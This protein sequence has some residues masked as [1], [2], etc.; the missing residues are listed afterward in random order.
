MLVSTFAVVS[1]EYQRCHKVKIMYDIKIQYVKNRKCE[2][3]NIYIY[4]QKSVS[5]H[6]SCK[7]LL[8]L[9][10]RDPWLWYP[11]FIPC[12]ISVYCT[13]PQYCDTVHRYYAV[14]Y[15][16]MICCTLRTSVK[17]DSVIMSKM[18]SRNM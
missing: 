16:S 6:L 13:V 9:S 11:M 2:R 14:N 5:K 17:S 18:V 3:H 12:V 1:I 15:H 7:S 8:V 10:G 4:I